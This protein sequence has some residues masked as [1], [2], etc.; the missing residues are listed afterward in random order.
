MDEGQFAIGFNKH[1]S[2]AGTTVVHD[3]ELLYVIFVIGS[4]AY[5]SALALDGELIWQK[6]IG[7]YKIQQGYGSSPMVFGLSLIHI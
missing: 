5:A 3:G 6:P 7:K 4:Q 2:H 1:A